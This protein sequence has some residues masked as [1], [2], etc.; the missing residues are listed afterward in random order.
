MTES[1]SSNSSRHSPSA[2]TQTQIPGFTADGTG[3]EPATLN[4]KTGTEKVVYFAGCYAN[5]FDPQIG[6]AFVEVMEANGIEV[7]VAEQKCCGIPMMPNGDIEGAKKNF[8]EIVQFLSDMAAPGLDIITTCPS[9][10]FILKKEGL[11]FFDS[12]EARFV[13]SRVLDAPEYLVRLFRQGR[14][15]TTFRETALKVLYHNPCHLKVQGLRRETVTLLGLIPGIGVSKVVDSCCGMGGSYGM[16]A[17]HY[18]MSVKIARK[19][20]A[21]IED[22]E[23]DCV[24]TECG[25][26]MLQIEA[27]QKAKKAVHPIVLIS[28]AYKKSDETRRHP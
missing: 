27:C 15:D 6:V 25:T 22:A 14:L 5:Y 28:D 20:W 13:S 26:C 3:T 23:V 12:E 17:A 10:N 1:Q 19:L 2:V 16:K 9:C 7:L 4:L 11:P 21:E 18:D 24:A 8:S